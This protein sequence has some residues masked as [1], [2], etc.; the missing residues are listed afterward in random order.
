MHLHKENIVQGSPAPRNIVM[1]PGPLTLP[2]AQRSLET[3]SFRIID[4]G[5]AKQLKSKASDRSVA[6][7]CWDEEREAELSLETK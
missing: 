7:T 6:R 1:Q 3:P 2:P 4:F 5:R